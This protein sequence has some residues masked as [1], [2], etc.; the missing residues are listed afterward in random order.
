MLEGPIGR[1]HIS[2]VSIFFCPLE[3]ESLKGKTDDETI[4][5]H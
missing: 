1:Y 4:H 2:K 5:S 3:T